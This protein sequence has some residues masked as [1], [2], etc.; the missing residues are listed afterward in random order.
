MFHEQL[1]DLEPCRVCFWTEYQSVGQSPPSTVS[2]SV[3]KISVCWCII[4]TL[5]GPYSSL[6]YEEKYSLKVC[7]IV[8]H[9]LRVFNMTTSF[10][11]GTVAVFL[12]N[13]VTVF[14]QCSVS[15]ACQPGQKVCMSAVSLRLSM[16]VAVC[17]SLICRM[18]RCVDDRTPP[19]KRVS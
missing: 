15:F 9:S 7:Y 4:P 6:L 13:I 16:H 19:K 1:S 8:Y 12:H 18:N 11:F 2:K 3:L 14:I 10:F 5:E 17:L